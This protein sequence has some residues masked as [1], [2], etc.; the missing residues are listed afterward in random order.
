MTK[1]KDQ[2][3]GRAL[4]KKLKTFENSKKTD[5]YEL[6]LNNVTEFQFQ[7]SKNQFFSNNSNNILYSLDS[8]IDICFKKGR[9]WGGDDEE[10]RSTG[11]GWKGGVNDEKRRIRGGWMEGGSIL[12]LSCL[13]L[14][15]NKSKIV[16]F[17]FQ[18]IVIF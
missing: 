9:S 5:V 3:G 11:E 2:G 6:V 12:A 18:I 10:E 15:V 14:F 7:F 16:W 13:V 17:P 4:I 1:L 8:Q